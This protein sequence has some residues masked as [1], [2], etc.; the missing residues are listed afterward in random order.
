MPPSATVL[1]PAASG[2]A[3]MSLN[4]D[5]STWKRVT[6]ATSSQNVTDRSRQPVD[7]RRRPVRR[8][9]STSTP[10]SCDIQRWG[11]SRRN[12]RHSQKLRFRSGTGALRPRRTY[13][14]QGGASRSSRDLLSTT[15][16]FF[17][18]RTGL[19]SIRTSCRS[20]CRAIASSTAPSPSRF[21]S[22]SPTVNWRDLKR[23]RVRSPAPRRAEAHRRPPLGRGASSARP[24]QLRRGLGASL[25]L[26]IASQ[27]AGAH[28]GS[29]TRRG[30]RR[31]PLGSIA[32]PPRMSRPV[33]RSR[34]AI[35]V[36][37]DP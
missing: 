2:G 3:G 12:G 37:G 35:P 6:L 26:Q 21:G 15:S 9:L 24:A 5:K 8:R 34:T 14:Q 22:L 13:Q 1:A 4:L 20:S 17:E 18:P 23:L 32:S 10:T 11:T 7:G 25:Q 31:T 19:T 30:H 28:F 16:S 27:L 36:L 29:A 33:R